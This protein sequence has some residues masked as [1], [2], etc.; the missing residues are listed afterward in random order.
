MT[1]NNYVQSNFEM[2]S[3]KK[4]LVKTIATRKGMN[5]KEFVNYAIDIAIKGET[6]DEAYLLQDK[7]LLEKELKTL[8]YK[9]KKDKATIENKIKEIDISLVNMNVE[10]EEKSEHDDYNKLVTMV[11]NGSRIKSIED[12]ILDHAKKYNVDVV[13]LRRKIEKDVAYKKFMR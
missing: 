4:E 3:D 13:E 6:K 7:Q 11:Y 9:Y 1:N 5:F 10:Y 8:E 2:D 12:L